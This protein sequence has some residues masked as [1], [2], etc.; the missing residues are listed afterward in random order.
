[1]A[2]GD[3]VPATLGSP[4]LGLLVVLTGPSGAGKDTLLDGLVKRDLGF[5]RARTATTRVPRDEGERDHY[6]FLSREQFEQLEAA[7]GLLES[8]E[9][10][11]NFYGVPAD[12]VLPRLTSGLNVAVRTEVLGARALRRLL[13]GG[14]TV[15]IA[16]PSLADLKARILDRAAASGRIPEAADLAQ[17]LEKAQEEMRA[18][19]EFDYKIV[20]RP[21]MA[22]VALDE[23]AS[24]VEAE[25]ARRRAG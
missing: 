2:G 20:N 13:P 12:E 6:R 16:P 22:D 14:V 23:L 11:G 1:V 8:A 19:D 3:E 5:A 25:L 18:Q 15:F 4:P 24:L 17:R 7:G 10:V 9:F 21:A